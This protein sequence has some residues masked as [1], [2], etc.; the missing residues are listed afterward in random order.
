MVDLQGEALETAKAQRLHALRLARRTV[1][2]NDALSLLFNDYAER[3]KTRPGGY[4]RIYKLGYR[5]G[6]NAPM[7]LLELLPAEEETTEFSVPEELA[8]E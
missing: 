8:E 7:S 4:T 5:K 3:F 1:E 6:D 2:D